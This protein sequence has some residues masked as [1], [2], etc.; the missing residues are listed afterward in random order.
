M[1]IG[2]WA[3][4]RSDVKDFT[5]YWLTEHHK[6]QHYLTEGELDKIIQT[7]RAKL[8]QAYEDVIKDFVT[9]LPHK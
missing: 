6:E 8:D 4:S 5:N 7:L 1:P 2:F 3:V 9:H